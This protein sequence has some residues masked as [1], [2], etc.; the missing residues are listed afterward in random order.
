MSEDL[1]TNEYEPVAISAL[2]DYIYC[3]RR[4]ALHRIEGCWSDNAY[5][6]SGTLLHE[7]VDDPGYRQNAEDTGTWLRTERAL[8]LFSQ[9]LGLVGKGDLVEFHRVP[10]AI[11]GDMPP[12]YSC[13]GPGSGHRWGVAAG[14]L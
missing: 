5:T 4:C 1:I 7:V 2:N 13:G 11:E 6:V 9:R 10:T 8:P 3:P 12:L 14:G